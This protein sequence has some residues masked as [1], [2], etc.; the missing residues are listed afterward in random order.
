MPEAQVDRFL[1]KINI[2]YPT[3]EE[4]SVSDARLT[5]TF[6]KDK[7]HAMQKGGNEALSYEEIIKMVDIAHEKSKE[8]EKL[9]L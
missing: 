8:L 5:V 7:I 6:H 4:E 1:F 9:L 3:Y 2:T